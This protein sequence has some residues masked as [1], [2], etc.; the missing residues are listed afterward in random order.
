MEHVLEA[1]SKLRLHS[2]IEEVKIQ[3]TRKALYKAMSNL[4]YSSQVWAPQ[5]VKLIEIIERVQ[6]RATKYTLM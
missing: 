6:R 3:S 5:S 4:S 1:E 2:K